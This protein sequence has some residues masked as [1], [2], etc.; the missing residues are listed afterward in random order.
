V[1]FPSANLIEQA[2]HSHDGGANDA[3]GR[4]GPR[5]T[6]T[7][8]ALG[9]TEWYEIPPQVGQGH[10]DYLP[11]PDEL[12]APYPNGWSDKSVKIGQL[13]EA[14]LDGRV[15]PWPPARPVTPHT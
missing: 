8:R 7:S 15:P 3:M 2:I 12:V 1:A 4:Y 11:H 6:A 10:S 9:K 14:V 13:A 5:L